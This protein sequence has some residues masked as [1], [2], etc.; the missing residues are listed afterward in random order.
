MGF[1]DVDKNKQGKYLSGFIVFDFKRLI[2]YYNELN[3]VIVVANN[4]ALEDI[5]NKLISYK[6]ENIALIT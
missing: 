4:K 3:C 6:I 5:V 2:K 1:C